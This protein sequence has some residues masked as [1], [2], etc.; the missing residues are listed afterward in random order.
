MSIQS[1]IEILS[2]QA[3]EAFAKE[4][5]ISGEEVMEYIEQVIREDLH[6]LTAF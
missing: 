1:D 3:M 5:H 6:R 2:I 4:N